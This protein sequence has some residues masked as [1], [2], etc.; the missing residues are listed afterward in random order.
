M[1]EGCEGTVNVFTAL[2][3]FQESAKA[4]AHS[5]GSFWHLFGGELSELK[6]CGWVTPSW[7]IQNHDLSLSVDLLVDAHSNQELKIDQTYC[8]LTMH[9]VSFVTVKCPHLS[10]SAFG[11]ISTRTR[12]RNCSRRLCMAHS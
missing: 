4:R 3:C 10:R 6:G 9:S 7:F 12:P 5:V 8:H 1:H 11:Q 2:K